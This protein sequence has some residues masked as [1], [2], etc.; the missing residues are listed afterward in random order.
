[1]IVKLSNENVSGSKITEILG[2]NRFTISKFLRRFKT[3]GMMENRHR[4]GRQRK[5]DDQA[6]RRLLRVVKNHRRKTLKDITFTFN[7]HKP[8][9]ISQETVKRRLKFHGYKRRIVKKKIV[10]SRKNRRTRRAWCRSKLHLMVNN[11]WRKIIFSDETQVVFGKDRKMYIWRRQEE[12]WAPRCLGMHADPDPILKTSVMFRGC[13]TYSGVGTLVPVNGNINS[14][15][16]VDILE[17]NLWPVVTIFFSNRLVLGIPKM[18]MLP[19]YL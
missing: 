11:Y 4:T 7:A 5:T 17:R 1:M 15:K 12:K 6:D 16:Y 18:T 14:E 13:I 10:I 9:K 2:L 8:T 19:P 3:T